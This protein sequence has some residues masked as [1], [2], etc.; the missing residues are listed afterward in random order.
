MNIV[1][2]TWTYFVIAVMA[3]I[4]ALN[5]ELFVFPNRF[6][7]A[8]LN[9]ICTMIQYISGISVGYLSLIINIPLAIWVYFRV[10]KPLAVRSMV[11]VLVNSLA[12]VMLNKLEVSRFAYFTENGTS[13]ILGPLVAGIVFGGCYSIIVQCRANS[14]GTDFIA[15]IIHKFRPDKNI[16]W[17]I[18]GLNV[19]VAFI[20]FF[21]YDYEIEPVILC[22]LY[23]FMSSTVTDKMAKN[24]RSA[25]RF[26]IVTEDPEFISRQ[27]IQRLHHSA[28]LIPG[29]GM[30][31]GKEVN[32]LICIVNRSQV[33]ALSAIIRDC[34]HTFA[35]MSQV[36]EVMGNFKK[37]DNKGHLEKQLLDQG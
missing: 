31:L 27:I 22:I 15:A 18:F 9:G 29:K 25:V 35:V 4:C 12:L 32:I 2:K 1:K 17:L 3:V 20:S 10:N 7:P 16:F 8:G 34:P 11:Y 19:V 21:V 6:A 5:Y 26:E 13:T 23:C 36:N 24:V 33:A 37:I 14:G 28:T 30:Y